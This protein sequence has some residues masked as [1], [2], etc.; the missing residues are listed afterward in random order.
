MSTPAVPCSVPRA[1]LAD[2]HFLA[3][4]AILAITAGAW[5]P[6]THWLDIHT[7]KE[8]VRWPARIQVS[9]DYRCISLDGNLGPFKRVPPPADPN[10]QDWEVIKPSDMETLGIGSDPGNWKSRRSNWYLSLLYRDL[11]VQPGLGDWL[12]Q[13]FYYTGGRDTVPHVTEICAVA[14]GATVLS[15]DTMH[16][17][18]SKSIDGWETKVPFQRTRYR[19]KE[20]MTRVDYYTFSMNGEFGVDRLWVR[21]RL[22]NPF[23]RYA[24]FAKIQFSPLSGSADFDQMDRSAEEFLQYALPE[25]LKALPS[26]RDVKDL[27]Q[28][29]P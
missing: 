11:R 23:V 22:I 1:L 5:G 2:R 3:A 24:Y 20:G 18:I 28:A 9:P 14:G 10:F 25:V 12:V 4:A 21:R 17:Q 19:M 29:A 13:V 7:L 15:S 8:R 6:V 27:E 26:G 16:F